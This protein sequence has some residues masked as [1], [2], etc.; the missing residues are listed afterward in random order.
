M[1]SPVTRADKL[2]QYIIKASHGHDALLHTL[3]KF[4]TKTSAAVG[5]QRDIQIH[6]FVLAIPK[7]GA[8]KKPITE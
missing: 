4:G 7:E 8:I 3:T 5:V 2:N 1:S 6:M